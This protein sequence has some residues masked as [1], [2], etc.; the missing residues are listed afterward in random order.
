VSRTSRS[1]SGPHLPTAPLR[2]LACRR[3]AQLAGRTGPCPCPADLLSLFPS[4]LPCTCDGTSIW[5]LVT[6]SS[7]TLHTLPEAYPV[8]MAC[9]ASNLLGSQAG[10]PCRGG[11]TRRWPGCCHLPPESLISSP[12]AVFY[13]KSSVASCLRIP[14]RLHLNSVRWSLSRF[15]YLLISPACC[16]SFSAQEVDEYSILDSIYYLLARER[17]M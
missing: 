9:D 10:A 11:T 1:P 4:S 2:P 13:E 15:I 6:C 8:A 16:K 14:P 12:K 5:A 17:S 7:T 3:S